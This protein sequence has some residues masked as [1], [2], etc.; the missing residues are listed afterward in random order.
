MRR[1]KLA[2]AILSAAPT[3]TPATAASFATLPPDPTP[4]QACAN[5]A[6]A[7]YKWDDPTVAEPASADKVHVDLRQG[8]GPAIPPAGRR[9]SL[10]ISG[11]MGNDGPMGPESV[12]AWQAADGVWHVSRV[13]HSGRPPAMPDYPA[14]PQWPEPPGT[15]ERGG[16]VELP[17]GTWDVAEGELTGEQA[18]ELEALLAAPCFGREPASLPFELP[19]R[20]GGKEYCV[21]DSASWGIAIRDGGTTRAYYRPCRL[22]GPVGAIVGL[23]TSVPLHDA[24]AR[25]SR[26]DLYRADDNPDAGR[27]HDFLAHRLPGARWESP[28]L[29]EPVI[30][31]SYRRTGPC[32]GEIVATSER[33][34]TAAP[35][36]FT[37]DWTS[38]KLIDLWPDGATARIYFDEDHPDRVTMAGT[39]A[40]LKV[41]GAVAW[42]PVLCK[43]KA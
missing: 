34:P 17:D 1:L 11:G 2:I 32:S 21:P 41:E 24:G 8:H 33:D 12:I 26:A 13:F 29:T 20:R 28:T 15:V 18:A 37:R 39:V 7:R 27:L 36:T 40:A 3:A 30:V 9:I 4:A 42:L 25:I 23:I 31:R 43:P 16:I 6:Q 38:T 10:T 14:P 5:L 35:V 19:L 22:L